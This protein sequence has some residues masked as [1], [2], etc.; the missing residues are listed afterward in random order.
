[1]SEGRL[2]V[3]CATPSSSGGWG[4][5]TALAELAGRM[6]DTTPVY[7][8]PT[9]PAG[10]LRK[11]VAMLPRRRRSDRQLLLIAAQPGDLL[12]VARADVLAGR[13]E[14][15]GAWIIDSFWDER[16][17]LFART[18][19]L[20]DRIWITDVELMDRYASAT[21]AECGWLPWGTD[22]LAALP[23][24]ATRR[25]IDVLRLGRQPQ[26]WD[27]DSTTGEALATNGI[28]FQGRFPQ[29]DD[30]LAN[31]QAVRDHLGRSRVVLASGNL[32]SPTQY[33]HPTRD[34]LSA[35]FTDAVAAGTLIAGAR[36]ACSASDLIP[37]EAWIDIDVTSR[38]RGLSAIMDAVRGHTDRTVAVLR[39]AA[40]ERLDWR[41]R[42]EQIRRDLDVASPTLDRELSDLRGAALHH[43]SLYPGLPL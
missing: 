13:F 20:V 2:Q 30:G 6:W 41:Y 11:A 3:W 26:A 40:L 42:L 21:T 39:S 24:P 27:D 14:Q 35:R 10:P 37:D 38:A 33:G 22:A 7:F 12:T 1:M 36:P 16:I 8:H 5:V 25:D 31:Q 28:R 19:H 17:P 15:I 32:A 18:R 9:A 34:Y 43:R 29:L 23:R 4:P